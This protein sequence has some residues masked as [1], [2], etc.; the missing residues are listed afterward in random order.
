[1]FVS[2]FV[3]V[4]L[5]IRETQR[6][7]LEEAGTRLSTHALAADDEAAE[8]RLR[9]GPEIW[10]RQ[11]IGKA[12]SVELGATRV[13]GDR[14]VI[15]LRWEGTGTAGA[16]FPDLDADLELAPLGPG[17]TQ[18]TLQGR[19]QPPVP[20]IGP[21]MDRLVLHRLAQ[22]SIRAFLRRLAEALDPDKD[23]ASAQPPPAA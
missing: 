6:R 2:D 12:V 4:D 17:A 19:Y 11:V 14:L 7:L 16:I 9:V 23:Q 13:R 22:S 20:V 10:G 8:L 15:A 5:P 1:M 21:G 3:I 18:V